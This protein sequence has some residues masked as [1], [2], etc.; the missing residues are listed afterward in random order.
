MGQLTGAG[1]R[2]EE[3]KRIL[4]TAAVPAVGL[5]TF[6]IGGYDFTVRNP[7]IAIVYLMMIICMF[8]VWTYLEEE[9]K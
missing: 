8:M 9:K 1:Y 6:W 7:I 3:M 5:S 4:A 2:G